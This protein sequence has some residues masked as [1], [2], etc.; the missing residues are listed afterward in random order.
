MFVTAMHG[1][2]ATC[3][4]L[5]PELSLGSMREVCAHVWFTHGD[6]CFGYYMCY[7][8]EDSHKCICF[9]DRAEAESCFQQ[10]R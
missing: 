1:C 9:M 8:D 4:G 3:L 5:R 10:L 2:M 6:T 7:Q